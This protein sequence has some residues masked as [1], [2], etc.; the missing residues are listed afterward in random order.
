MTMVMIS[1]TCLENN[2]LRICDYIF[3]DFLVLFAFY[4]VGEVR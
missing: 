4:N 2:H 1:K 3:C